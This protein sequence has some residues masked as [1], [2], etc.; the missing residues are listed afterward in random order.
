[1]IVHFELSERPGSML[2]FGGSDLTPSVSSSSYGRWWFGL[3]FQLHTW[4]IAIFLFFIAV[5]LYSLV[6]GRV[7]VSLFGIAQC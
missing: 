3:F 7:A 2:A 6:L 1:M 4:P 5:P